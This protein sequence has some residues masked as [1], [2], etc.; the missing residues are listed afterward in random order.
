MVLIHAVKALGGGFKAIIG[1]LMVLVAY[2][3]GFYTGYRFHELQA[4]AWDLLPI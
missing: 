1:S 2:G 4:W 3:F